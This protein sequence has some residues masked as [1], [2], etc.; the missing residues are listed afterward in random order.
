MRFEIPLVA[1]LAANRQTN[2]NIVVKKLISL[3]SVLS[4]VNHKKHGTIFAPL[5]FLWEDFMEKK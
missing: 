4:C 5:L 1:I 2:V 3:F